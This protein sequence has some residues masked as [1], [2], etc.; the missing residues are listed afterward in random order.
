MGVGV[1]D[2]RELL[3]LKAEIDALS[4]PDRLRLAASL[5]EQRKGDLAHTIAERVVLE[6]GAALALRKLREKTP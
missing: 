6:L 5:M 4:A 3:A 1:S 2:Q